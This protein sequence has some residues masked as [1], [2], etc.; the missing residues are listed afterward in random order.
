[1]PMKE[2]VLV[3]GFHAALRPRPRPPAPYL[4]LDGRADSLTNVVITKAVF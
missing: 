4:P 2:F 3:P 1:M